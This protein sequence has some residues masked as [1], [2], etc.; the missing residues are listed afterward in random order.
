MRVDYD[1]HVPEILRGGT[2]HRGAAD[3]Y[4]LDGLFER[5]AFARDC[6]LERVE[7]DDDH[8]NQFDA[9]GSGGVHVLRVIAQRE[10]AAVYAR[11][12]GLDATIHHFGKARHVRD[13]AYFQ[14]G[15]AQD[16]RRPARADDL[17]IEAAQLA[18]EFDDT[19]L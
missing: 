15:L 8:I 13:V 9:V 6:L 7:V 16:L 17:H 12:E 14:P 5:D 2:N 10:Q 11:V 19:R 3:V 1:S 4:L 18:R